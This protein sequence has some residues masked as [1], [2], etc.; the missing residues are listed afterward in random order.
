MPMTG[1]VTMDVDKCS[2]TIGEWN[3]AMN[4]LPTGGTIDGDQVS[5]DGDEFWQACTGTVSSDGMAVTGA[6]QDGS[7]LTMTAG[8]LT[9]TDTMTGTM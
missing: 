7:E 3:M 4:S 8:A 5:F 9:M 1:S 6:C 2:F